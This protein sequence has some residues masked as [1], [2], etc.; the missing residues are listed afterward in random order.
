MI[1]VY[2]IEP[3]KEKP[4]YAF[5]DMDELDAAMQGHTYEMYDY[6]SDYTQQVE[7]EFPL[8]RLNDLVTSEPERYEDGFI[9]RVYAGSSLNLVPSGKFYMPFACSNLT[10]CPICKGSGHIDNPDHAGSI[11]SAAKAAQEAL[12]SVLVGNHDV[13]AAYRELSKIVEAR[14]ETLSCPCCDGMGSHE[15]AADER[16]MEALA[17]HLDKEDMWQECGEGDSLSWFICKRVDWLDEESAF[18]EG[19]L[20]ELDGNEDLA[21]ECL[22]NAR[23]FLGRLPTWDDTFEVGTYYGQLK[24]Y[25]IDRSG[26]TIYAAAA[27]ADWFIGRDEIRREPPKI[28]YLCSSLTVALSAHL[29]RRLTDSELGDFIRMNTNRIADGTVLGSLAVWYPEVRLG[30]RGW[31]LV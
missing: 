9:G 5:E 6:I 31:E 28:D 18:F 15:A 13:Q 14:G 16:F 10:P 11:L 2:D 30:I 26:T 24:K 4:W 17:A 3:A 21:L 25:G 19:L 8:D 1:F 22:D 27:A 20:E 7:A 29:G 23:E 12:K